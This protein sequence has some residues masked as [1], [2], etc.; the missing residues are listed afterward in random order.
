MVS[1]N[2]DGRAPDAPE[3]LEEFA[4]LIGCF[5]VEVSMWNADHESWSEP[6]TGHWSGRW[7]MDGWAIQD[8][9]SGIQN[10]GMRDHMGR[11]MNI[12]TY[13]PDGHRWVIAWT[14]VGEQGVRDRRARRFGDSI[15]V[16][17]P[18]P[19]W[20]PGWEA[21]FDIDESGHWTRTELRSPDDENWTPE[22]KMVARPVSCD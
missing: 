20:S 8:E 14:H 2:V 21:Q 3:E 13:D 19:E 9:W 7:A 22:R 4:F 17:Q 16:W 11:G 18:F 12:R 10:P 5:D 1:S 15:R 6:V